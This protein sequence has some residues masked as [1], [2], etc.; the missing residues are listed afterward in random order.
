MFVCTGNTCRSP[1]AHAFMLDLLGKMNMR[2]VEVDSAGIGCNFGDPISANSQEVLK[3]NGIE[4]EHTSKPISL[5]DIKESDYI[6]CMT[7]SHKMMLSAFAPKEKLFCIDDITHDGD[8]IEIVLKIHV[9]SSKVSLDISI[10]KYPAKHKRIFPVMR[11]VRFCLRRKKGR[12]ILYS[13]QG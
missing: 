3:E 2:N 4:F 1:L 11:R 5:E 8:V 6:I 13:I 9:N 7:K 12:S 10:A